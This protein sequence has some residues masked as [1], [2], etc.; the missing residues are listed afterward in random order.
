MADV[1]VSFEGV[2][3][4][5]KMLLMIVQAFGVEDDVSKEDSIYII[6]TK[7]CWKGCLVSIF[8]EYSDLMVATFKVN[9][10]KVD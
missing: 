10:T 4:S 9:P 6:Q 8:W 1:I 5:L 7:C 2:P 3:P